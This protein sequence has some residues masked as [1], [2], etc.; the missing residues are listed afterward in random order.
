MGGEKLNS[1]R[2]NK[3]AFPAAFLIIA[4]F[5]TASSPLFAQTVDESTL[6]L[7]EIPPA[8]EAAGGSSIMIILRMVL[9]L[10]LAALAI[11]G[12]VFFIRRLAKP[13]ELLDPH[14]KVLARVP[15]GNDSFAAVLSVGSKA[16][17][18]GGGTG[19]L[20]LISEIDEIEALE[21]MM[22]DDARKAAE[23]G[24]GPFIDFRSLISR[25]GAGRREGKKITSDGLNDP[26]A[27]NTLADNL[28]RQR[29]R[30]KRL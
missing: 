13:R 12:V 1:I 8:A 16:W 26:H 21:T 14:L 7:G 30:L 29:E 3:G 11:Y 4:V 5:L 18:V 23:S 20:S 17:L 6:I 27:E 15:L 28:R 24:S 10:A 2:P 25:F 19:G 9:V 22:L